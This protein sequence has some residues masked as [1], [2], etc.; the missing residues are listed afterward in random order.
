MRVLVEKLARLDYLAV[1]DAQSPVEDALRLLLTRIRGQ[2]D[3]D[4][5]F[6][7]CRAGIHDLGGLSLNDPAHVDVLVG[8]DSPQ[9]RDGPAL[10]LEVLAARRAP[11]DQ[12]VLLVQ[13]FA[14]L[15]LNGEASQWSQA[16]YRAAMYTA[17]QRT[18]YNKLEDPP[19]EDDDQAAH[20]PWP[21]AQR[22]N[23]G[24]PGNLADITK[25]TLLGQELQNLRARLQ[26]L[27]ADEGRDVTGQDD[28]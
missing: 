12:R 20:Y 21:V 17:C 25:E 18:L 3:P 10:T 15:P 22:T 11:I 23:L 24:S 13:T 19:A 28:E 7:D 16:R 5:I 14:P 4:Y 27:A 6:L 26:A 8:R 2:H 9:G 1:A